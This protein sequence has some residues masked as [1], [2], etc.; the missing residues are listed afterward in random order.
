MGYAS[1]LVWLEGGWQAQAAP[2]TWYSA[3]LVLNLAWPLT[4]FVAKRI[5]LAEV[6]NLGA[7]LPALRELHSGARTSNSPAALVTLASL[8]QGAAA[9]GPAAAA[10]EVRNLLTVC[11]PQPRWPR[12]PS[13]PPCSTL[14]TSF[15][16]SSCCPT[17]CVLQQLL[18]CQQL[19]CPGCSL[20]TSRARS[21]FCTSTRAASWLVWAP[22]LEELWCAGVARL[23]KCAQHLHPAQERRQGAIC[24]HARSAVGC[25]QALGQGQQAAAR[26][27]A[28][29]L[30]GSPA[31]G[32][33][34]TAALTRAGCPQAQAVM[35]D[36][37]H[38]PGKENPGAP[39]GLWLSG[40]RR[41]QQSA[42]PDAWP[43]PAL[44][45][46]VPGCSG[47]RPAQGLPSRRVALQLTA[48][49]PAGYLMEGQTP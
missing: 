9:C 25:T 42:S 17:W 23:C 32:A 8:L 44:C 29:E 27:F 39:R 15:R 41:L 13:R 6:V 14:S 24:P 37:R 1:Y 31:A 43:R 46:A 21:I 38:A 10:H 33:L 11:A 30:R 47:C 28:L 45:C 26:E 12:R 5:Q 19:G 4:F 20:P 48:P 35:E 49:S 18:S 7:L 22:Q 34:A 16:A 40:V 36:L 3:Q 2:L